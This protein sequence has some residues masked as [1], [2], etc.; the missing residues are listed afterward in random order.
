MAIANL[1]W[2]RRTYGRCWELT[3]LGKDQIAVGRVTRRTG[4]GGWEGWLIPPAMG[5]AVPLT[6]SP[7]PYH[8]TR[9]LVELAILEQR[10]AMAGGES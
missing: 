4:D 1:M 8:A 6:K 10:A 9:R 5:P 2:R 3:T 7:Q